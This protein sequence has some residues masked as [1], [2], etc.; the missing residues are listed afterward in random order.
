MELKPDYAMQVHAISSS[1]MTPESLLQVQIGSTQPPIC[2]ADGN[3]LPL[4][5]QPRFMQCQIYAALWP[6]GR[7]SQLG[8]YLILLPVQL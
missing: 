2:C 1:E 5:C 7:L 6:G 4:S 3:M 8:E